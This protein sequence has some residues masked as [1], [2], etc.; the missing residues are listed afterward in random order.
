MWTTAERLI[1]DPG[2]EAKIVAYAVMMIITA[3][4]LIM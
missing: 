4:E 3:C 2:L 1:L